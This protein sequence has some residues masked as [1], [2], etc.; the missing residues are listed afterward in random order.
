MRR[1]Q[2]RFN[3]ALGISA[4]EDEEKLTPAEMQMMLAR[5]KGGKEE[6]GFVGG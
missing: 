3:T 4:T 1:D 2:E 5:I 6:G